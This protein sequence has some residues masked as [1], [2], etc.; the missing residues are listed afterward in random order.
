MPR[1]IIGCVVI[2]I[3]A[4]VALQPAFT[5]LP[6]Q[7]VQAS[8]KS[9]TGPPEVK[10][11]E[12]AA[13]YSTSPQKKL[14]N[15]RE[16]LGSGS[17]E[18]KVLASLET[19]LAAIK[20]PPVVA[21]LRGDDIGQAVLAAEHFAKM[22]SRPTGPVGP[23]DKASSKKVW[24]FV[25]ISHTHSS[26]PRWIIHRPTVYGTGIRLTYTEYDG[27]FTGP[28]GDSVSLDLHPFLYWVPLGE[29][30]DPSSLQAELVY[31]Q[32]TVKASFPGK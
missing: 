24:L 28:G 18:E 19:A 23:D 30:S 12:F 16:S 22:K 25:Y 15:V 3:L 8:Q 10:E 2:G 21:V 27:W 7:I 14:K 31:L 29:Y 1:V 9:E 26:P 32:K 11:I 17:A 4:A 6:R 13:I 20:S 5:E